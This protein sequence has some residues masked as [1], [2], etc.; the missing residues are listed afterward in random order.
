MQ[1]PTI[2][3]PAMSPDNGADPQPG[4]FCLQV[5]LIPTWPGDTVTL[6]Y[7]GLVLSLL[8]LLSLTCVH[9]QF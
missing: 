1:F 4:A 7:A 9:L 3:P 6:D 8:N 2:K 5:S